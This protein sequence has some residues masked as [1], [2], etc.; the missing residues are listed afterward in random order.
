MKKN[1][2]KVFVVVLA[3]L[4]VCFTFV[5]CS[6]NIT[7]KNM[8]GTKWVTN[9]PN[10]SVGCLA[11]V[12][13]ADGTGALN[14]YANGQLV[15]SYAEFKWSLDDDKLFITM[16]GVTQMLT[17]EKTSS[18]KFYFIVEEMVFYLNN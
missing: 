9:D 14:S 10:D 11:F 17:I 12:F 5:S 1:F 16:S 7:S 2:I 4:L 15:E 18:N 8:A 6:S 13:N 3:V